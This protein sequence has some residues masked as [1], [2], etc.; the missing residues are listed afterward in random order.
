M[1]GSTVDPNHLL[2]LQRK[3]TSSIATL[4]SFEGAIAATHSRVPHELIRQKRA[5]AAHYFNILQKKMDNLKDESKNTEKKTGY[6]LML[7]P[8]WKWPVYKFLCPSDSPPGSFCSV[9]QRSLNDNKGVSIW[10]VP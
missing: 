2:E 1:A 10:N 7:S 3:L 5:E 4:K 8:I 9:V 6:E